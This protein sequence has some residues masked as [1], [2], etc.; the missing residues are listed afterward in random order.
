MITQEELKSILR[1]EKDTGY[2]VWLIS[3]SSKAKIGGVAGTINNRGYVQ[4]SIKRKLY[5]A[6]RLAWLYNYGEFPANEMDHINRIKSDNRLENLRAVTHQQNAFN[7]GAHK[8]SSSKYV[9]VSRYRNKFQAHIVLNGKT[10]YL[11]L[12]PNEEMAHKA[13]Q[14]AKQ[15]LHA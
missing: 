11:G 12:F 4:I 7:V 6:H 2:F 9:G 5:L 13:Y 1:Y 14:R 15:E 10:N 3:P 8:D